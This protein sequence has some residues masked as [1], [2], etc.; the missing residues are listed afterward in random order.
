MR[1]DSLRVAERRLRYEF[2]PKAGLFRGRSRQAPAVEIQGSE[3]KVPW[4]K[5]NIDE[6]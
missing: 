4:K 2:S 1:D 3:A 6:K 5:E